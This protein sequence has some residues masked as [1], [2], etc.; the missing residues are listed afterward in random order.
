MGNININTPFR[1]KLKSPARSIFNKKPPQSKK[2]ATT[3]M[4]KYHIYIRTIQLLLIYLFAV[5]QTLFGD[6]SKWIAIGMLHNWFSSTGCEIEI[7]RRGLISDQQDGMQWPALYRLTDMQ[8]AKAFWIGTKK[9]ND[10]IM[11]REYSF[12][13]V[14]NGPRGVDEH[15][16]FIPQSF[17]LV[18]KF[19]HPLVLVNQIPAAHTVYEDKVDE[20]DE[21]L[22]TDRMLYNKINTSLGIT[23]TRRIYVNSQQFHDNYFIFDYT[24]KNTGIY[25]KNGDIINPHR[26]LE[27]VIFFYQYRWAVSKYIGD[28][29]YRYAPQAATWGKSTVNR[30]LHPNYGDSIR[31]S[32]AYLGQFSEY[33]GDNIGGPNINGDGFL[34]AAQFPGVVTIH[35]DTA[36][37]DTTDD[38]S[39]PAHAP[40]FFSGADI[41]Q[42]SFNDQFNENNMTKEYQ[43]MSS[44]FPLVT[45][46]EMVGDG[47]ADELSIAGGGGVS[48]GIGYGPFTIPPNDSIHIVMA[49][50]ANGIDWEKCKTIGN[51]WMNE[52]EPYILPDGSETSDKNQYK[53]KWVF[54]GLDSLMI[55]FQRAQNVWDNGMVIDPPP[56][57]PDE[58]IITSGGD[59]ITLTWSNSAESYE[60]FAGYKIYRSKD[61]PDTSFTLIFECGQ[62]T[63]NPLVNTFEDRNAIRG[64]DYY[65]YITSFDDGTVS[66]IRPGGRVL[67]SSLFWTRTIEPANL[68]RQPGTSLDKIRIVPNPFNIASR[69]YQFGNQ[70]SRDQIMFYGLPPKCSIKIFTERGDLIKTINHNDSSGDEPWNS[71]TSAGQVIVSGIYI[72][73]IEVTEDT[74]NFNK[75]DGIAKKLIVVR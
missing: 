14:H 38:T 1:F 5:N 60:H 12:K 16:E 50:C 68:T 71:I 66:N 27:D 35:V 36:P 37:D 23:I 17:K 18:G 75:G 53:N 74:D 47:N 57:P 7:G 56:P 21:T 49:E 58:F 9:F 30:V 72:V 59:R 63:D 41:T 40:Y 43:T 62:G 29:G 67:E 70:S 33:D 22:L 55:T 39:Q 13:V 45:H 73:F 26:T 25:N 4:K 44:G 34:G 31:A 64:F 28:S 8:A 11:G 42:V 6:D 32:Y 51:K 69:S 65:Y 24:F 54:T 19:E 48:Q 15:N 10:P 52:I 20:I 61:T 46:E 2:D 3:L